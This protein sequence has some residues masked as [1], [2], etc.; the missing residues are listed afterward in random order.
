MV[1]KFRTVSCCAMTTTVCL[2]Y[3]DK[4]IQDVVER[5]YT[6][7]IVGRISQRTILA[8]SLPGLFTQSR[9]RNDRIVDIRQLFCVGRRCAAD[10]I[11]RVCVVRR[12]AGART[13]SASMRSSDNYTWS[14]S[15]HLF[16]DLHA[17]SND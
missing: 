3:V 14:H 9:V 17:V 13:V 6:Y 11:Q 2:D 5:L 10:S 15:V 8:I 4:P 7:L 1:Q 16:I 12:F